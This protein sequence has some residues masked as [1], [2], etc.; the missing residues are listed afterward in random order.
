MAKFNGTAIILD[1]DGSA[2]AHVENATLSINREIPEANDKDSAPWA[3][4][5]D[6]AGLMDWEISF[7]GN[8]DWSQ[9]TG[10]VETLFDL[11][12]GRTA[13]TTIFGIDPSQVTGLSV[14][15]AFSGDASFN[16]VELGAPMEETAPISGTAIGKG[17]LTKIAN[18]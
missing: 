15:L 17:T 9:T 14:G 12:T 2:V 3:D 5:L 10:N 18:S 8:A 6:E 16:G 13:V 1:A 4:H 7:D 11:L